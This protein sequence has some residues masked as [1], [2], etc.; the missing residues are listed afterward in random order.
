M[1]KLPPEIEI[2]LRTLP[3]GLREH[4]QR[5]REVGRELALR[6]GVDA[7]L[8]DQGTAA[9]DLARAVDEAVL[10]EQA[11]HYGLR[12][13]SV[14]RHSPMLL[15]GPV[16]ALW[17][18]HEDGV[19]DQCL[20]DAVR[21]HTTGKRGMGDVA[22]VV[23]LADKLDPCKVK[24]YPRLGAVSDLARDSLDRALLEYLNQE[25]D[26]LLGSGLSIHPASVELRNELIASQE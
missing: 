3:N 13:S 9:H 18:A 12:V 2:R 1:N 26:Y 22:K 19:E 20:L 24:R 17:L 8:V 23:F 21:W 5:V 25:L 10:L 16:A 15:H 11:R 6:H 7:G 4:V 14:E